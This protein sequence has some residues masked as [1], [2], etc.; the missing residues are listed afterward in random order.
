MEDRHGALIQGLYSNTA[1]QTEF[2][3]SNLRAHCEFD[4]DPVFEE[5][6]RV[7]RKRKTTRHEQESSC[8][9]L[10]KTVGQHRVEMAMRAKSMR[11]SSQA[12][13]K[14][15]QGDLARAIQEKLGQK[16][17]AAKKPTLQREASFSPESPQSRPRP[18]ARS[19]TSSFTSLGI[20]DGP[21]SSKFTASKSPGALNRWKSDQRPDPAWYKVQYNMVHGRPQAPDF[22]KRSRSSSPESG[23]VLAL[24]DGTASPKRAPGTFNLT[25]IDVEKVE[26]GWRFS[27]DESKKRAMQLAE[28]YLAKTPNWDQYNNMKVGRYPALEFHRVTE[29]AKD[30]YEQDLKAYHKQRIPAWD[31]AKVPGRP[32]QEQDDVA[33]PGKYD[34]NYSAVRGKIPSGV[35]FQRALPRALSDGRLGH[36]AL[37]AVLHADAKRFPGGVRFDTSASKDCVRR[38]MTLVNDFDRELPRPNPAPRSLE[39]HDPTDPEASEVTLRRMMSY[40][41]NVADRHVS[42]RRDMA[43]VYER[44]LPRGKE[45]VQ[46]MRA[47][48]TDLGVRGAAGLGF[49]ETTGQRTLPVEKLEGR[50]ANAAF[51]RPDI[52]PRFDHLTY[53]EALNLET[54]HNQGNIVHGAGPSFD[55]RPAP[56]CPRRV[57]GEMH[58]RRQ[59]PQGFSKGVKATGP[60]DAKVQRQ[61]RAYEAIDDWS[62]LLNGLASKREE[63]EK[64][65]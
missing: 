37:Q 63:S 14:S 59:V 42:T 26:D 8:N 31:F 17:A 23:E 61:S 18:P 41:P 62:Q 29:P 3:I 50:T 12:E 38:R 9:R 51:Q 27:D 20:Y 21:W 33:A 46:G 47:L 57:R 54:N 4:D 16:M 64:Q 65:H 11:S 49:I 58:F 35:G 30:L 52:G 2:E 56:R 44:M 60:A 32:G 22:Q 34:V 40:D 24:C 19:E 1:R 53:F 6:P 13:P 25:G 10:T 39:Y 5:T 48:Q 43:P 28:G 15:Q 45:A 7:T 36:F 55:T